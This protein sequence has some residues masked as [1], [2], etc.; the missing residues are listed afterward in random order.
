[1]SETLLAILTDDTARQASE[2]RDSLNEQFSAGATWF[3]AKQ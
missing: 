1:M 2:I 3:D